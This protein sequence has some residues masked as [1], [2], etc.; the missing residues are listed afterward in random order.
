MDRWLGSDPRPAVAEMDEM[1]DVVVRGGRGPLRSPE[2]EALLRNQTLNHMH[3][4]IPTVA[5]WDARSVGEATLWP[6]W[7]AQCSGGDHAKG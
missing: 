5:L 4:R 3:G 2:E 1:W 7:W 6:R